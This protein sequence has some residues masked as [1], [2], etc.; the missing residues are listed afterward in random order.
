VSRQ[1]LNGQREVWRHYLTYDAAM[2]KTVV[3][4]VLIV[5]SAPLSAQWLTHQDPRIPR[6]SD[7]KPNL[8]AP[9][10]LA[11]NGR[12]DLSGVWQVEATP[13][14]E[15]RRRFGD[16]DKL[17]VPG[18]NVLEFS[19]YMLNV[20]SDFTPGDSPLRPDAA[21]Q[22]QRSMANAAR[23][24]PPR[25]ACLPVCQWLMWLRPRTRLSRRRS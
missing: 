5:M 12:P 24:V 14:E 20:L 22:F 19:K 21:E 18:D 16:V 2:K 9:R 11:S 3:A 17:S 23:R 25:T 1:R 13:V 8:S 4:I 15:M 10:P 7:G 6:T